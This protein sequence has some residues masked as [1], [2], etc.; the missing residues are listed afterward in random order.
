MFKAI[1]YSLF[2][3]LY[4]VFDILEMTYA[5]LPR[6]RGVQI[7]TFAGTTKVASEAACKLSSIPVA[8]DCCRGGR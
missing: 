4:S 1:H 7:P 5:D 2:A 8:E 6:L 3:I